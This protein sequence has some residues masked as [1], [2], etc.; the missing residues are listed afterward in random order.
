[1]S[2]STWE[3]CMI[4]AWLNANVTAFLSATRL[5]PQW[6]SPC[7]TWC[8]GRWHAIR[9]ARRP[10]STRISELLDI[11]GFRG[12][13]AAAGFGGSASG[14]GFAA[15]GHEVEHGDGHAADEQGSDLTRHQ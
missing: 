11:W 7:A 12:G 1:M 5:P 2:P 14:T 9:S 6:S 10:F 15:I 3:C 13:R 8:A 4:I